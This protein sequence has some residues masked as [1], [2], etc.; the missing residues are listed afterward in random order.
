M[1]L[2]EVNIE[3]MSDRIWESLSTVTFDCT[4]MEAHNLMSRGS[5]VE[6]KTVIV[7]EPKLNILS[8]DFIIK[9]KNDI[10]VIFNDPAT[11]LFMNGK[12]YVS[13]AHNEP[14]DEEKGLLMCLAKA[15]GISHLELKRMIKGAK[16]EYKPL[17]PKERKSINGV[18]VK[19]EQLD[20]AKKRGRP[21]KTKE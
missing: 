21:K 3:S 5:S 4:A 9:T 10:K 1:R 13:K 12:K 17:P 6:Y 18:S 7:P 14:F 8:K 2:K 11:I 19:I 16:R 15:Q 20:L